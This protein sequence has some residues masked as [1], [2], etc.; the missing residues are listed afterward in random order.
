MTA[1]QA[2]RIVSK[3]ILHLRLI[4]KDCDMAIDGTWNVRDIGSIGGFEAMR[5]NALESRKELKAL[6]KT[7]PK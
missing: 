3:A 5:D 2:R 1:K 6:L 7:M 4:E